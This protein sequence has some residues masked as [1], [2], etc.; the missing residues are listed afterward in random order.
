MVTE[1]GWKP[2]RSLDV[3]SRRAKAAKIATLVERRRTLAG[4]DVLEIGT[5]GGIIAS[6]LAERAGDAGTVWSVDVDDLRTVTDG[7][8]FRLVEGVE[9]PFDDDRFDVVVSNHTIEHVGGPDAQLVHLREIARVLRPGGVGYLASPTRWALVE[10]HFKVPLLS[11]LPPGARSGAL[12]LSRRGAVY[13]IS[14]RTRPE[15]LRLVE[16]AGLRATDVTVDAL[17]V[18]A[19]IEAGAASRA[20]AALPGGVLTVARGA[21]PTMVFVL[22]H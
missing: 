9:L 17:R 3:E 19:E 16:Q 5:G 4:A 21:V 12:R 10:P 1:G 7:Y 14:P 15:L 2:K 18:T 13:D 8:R 22:E 20:A 6:L 11:W